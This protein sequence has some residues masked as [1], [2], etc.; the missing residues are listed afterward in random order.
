MK[1]SILLDGEITLTEIASLAAL[2][3]HPGWKVV[4]K[5]H[6][7]ACKRATE[8]VIKCDPVEDEG[9]D[10][11]VKALQLKARERNE[12][13]ML[14]LGSIELHVQSLQSQ[15]EPEAKEENRITKGLNNE[16]DT[17]NANV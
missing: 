12:F 14:V 1:Q 11:K 3:Q 5:M 8:A 16:S 2:V 17:R 10:R 13:S 6:T 7:A 9:Y 4:E 15:S